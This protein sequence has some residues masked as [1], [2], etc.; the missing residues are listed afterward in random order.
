MWNGLAD[1]NKPADKLS[2]PQ[3]LSST[4]QRYESTCCTDELENQE[5]V[6]F[7]VTT[8]VAGAEVYFDAAQLE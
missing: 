6:Q 4:W 2:Y 8:E 3:T 7:K 1:F 5:V